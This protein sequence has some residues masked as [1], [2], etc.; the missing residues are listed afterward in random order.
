MD[1]HSKDIKMTT[2]GSG[3]GSRGTAVSELA[4]AAG[5][6]PVSEVLK[7]L[8]RLVDEKFVEVVN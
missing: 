5:S 7:G 8:Q 3:S 6:L 2:P 4:K 1:A